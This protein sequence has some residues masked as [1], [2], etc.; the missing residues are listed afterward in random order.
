MIQCQC[1]LAAWVCAPKLRPKVRCC[2][3][4]R[5]R[6][7]RRWQSASCPTLNGQIAAHTERQKNVK[8][9]RS[10]FLAKL[11]V[12][13]RKRPPHATRSFKKSQ[14][15]QICSDFD[16]TQTNRKLIECSTTLVL[17]LW[18]SGETVDRKSTKTDAGTQRRLPATQIKRHF[19]ANALVYWTR[20]KRL[21]IKLFESYRLVYFLFRKIV[22]ISLKI[23]FNPKCVSRLKYPTN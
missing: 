6:S 16:E 22:T 4:H 5:L 18:R 14:I 17:S 15:P 12:C 10:N 7:M 21:F 3:C 23:K 11:F 19:Q 9:S 20:L 1:H 13:R 2:R 8:K